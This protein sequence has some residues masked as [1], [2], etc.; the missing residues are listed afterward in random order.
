M[1]IICIHSVSAGGTNPT[2]NRE[3]GD[4][5]ATMKKS[6]VPKS[7]VQ[8]IFDNVVCYLKYQFLF[9]TYFFPVVV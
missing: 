9:K 6:G 3:L 4:I 1:I 7:D 5:L 8:K 2:T